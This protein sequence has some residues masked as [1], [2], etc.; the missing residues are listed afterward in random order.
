MKQRLGKNTLNESDILCFSTDLF[1]IV[2]QYISLESQLKQKDLE[3]EKAKARIRELETSLATQ[4]LNR[5]SHHKASPKT[6]KDEIVKKTLS[7]TTNEV[8]K[9]TK[10]CVPES[11]F[12]GSNKPSY[13][14]GTEPLQRSKSTE[15]S[16]TKPNRINRNQ[17]KLIERSRSS[18]RPVSNPKTNIDTL[19]SFRNSNLKK[20]EMCCS[21][22]SI[23]SSD[24][25]RSKHCTTTGPANQK[26]VVQNVGTSSGYSSDTETLT[27]N[28]L[29]QVSKVLHA[30]AKD[31]MSVTS[32]DENSDDDD[33]S[34]VSDENED[35]ENILSTQS[36]ISLGEKFSN[37]LR[38]T[39]SLNSSLAVKETNV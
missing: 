31:E 14:R 9:K 33:S 6:T 20:S 39:I 19:K 35:L 30:Q 13:I 8:V 16:V 11:R 5:N 38:R 27:L 29:L 2:L 26:E 10:P 22:N 1:F 23:H 24:N 36:N 32:D 17:S 37:D 25:G 15:L 34:G 3:L 28:T 12:N 4:H 18:E 7:R 21:C